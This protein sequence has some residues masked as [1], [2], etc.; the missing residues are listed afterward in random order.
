MTVRK[1]FLTKYYM[2][3]TAFQRNLPV[4]LFDRFYYLKKQCVIHK[5]IQPY[6]NKIILFSAFLKVLNTML[7]EIENLFYF[8]GEIYTNIKLK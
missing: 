4:Q 5:K 3:K 7:F 6:K 8:F 1:T 2:C